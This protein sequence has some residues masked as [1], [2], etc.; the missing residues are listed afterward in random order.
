MAKIYWRR[1]KA[2]TRFFNDVPSDELKEEI[3]KLAKHDVKIGVITAERYLELIG[4][5]YQ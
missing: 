1:I 4:E 5:V 3:K 2:G